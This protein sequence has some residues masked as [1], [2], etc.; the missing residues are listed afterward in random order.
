MHRPSG[1][2][3]GTVVV[4]AEDDDDVRSLVAEALRVAGYIVNEAHDGAELIATSGLTV[5]SS[6]MAVADVR[7]P[8]LS[9]LGVLEALN[10][11]HW[12]VPVV[13]TA[14]S[15]HLSVTR[16]ARKLGAVGVLHKP[17]DADDLVTAVYNARQVV[18]ARE[19]GSR[20]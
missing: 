13:M 17:F 1:P 19:A 11:V 9:G 2:P 6:I 5:P 10:R 12:D 15:S 20:G 14:S 4:V 16:M 8:R 3:P 7:M 18:D